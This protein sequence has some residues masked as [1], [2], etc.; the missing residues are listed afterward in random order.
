MNYEV[1]EALGQIA[2]EKNVDK[3]LVIETLEI[4]LLSATKRR[5][6]T[7][8]NVDSFKQSSLNDQDMYEIP[9]PNFESRTFIITEVSFSVAVLN[10]SRC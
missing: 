7:S 5:F 3:A 6:G 2:Q 9:F 1:L 4:G 8:D 10:F